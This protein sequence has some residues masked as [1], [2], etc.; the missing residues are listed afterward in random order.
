MDNLYREEIIEH[1]KNPL[2]FGKLQKFDAT[3]MQLNPFC[4]DEISMFVM[5]KNSKKSAGVAT[6]S[7][8][9][10]KVDAISFTGKGCA[11][12]IAAASMLTEHAKD[13]SKKQLTKFTEED[14]LDLLGIAVSET[15]KKCAF[16]AL[17]TL[18]DCLN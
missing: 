11:L 12:S 14:M 17:F 13:K 3:S 9:G 15:R 10:W 1:Y 4:G 8:L 2:N 7:P 5:F 16:L 18:R 6:V